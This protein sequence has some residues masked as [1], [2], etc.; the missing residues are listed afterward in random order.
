VFKFPLLGYQAS[1]GVDDR[2][3]WTVACDTEV[4]VVAIVYSTL[5]SRLI[6][7]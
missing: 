4:N 7:D 3:E 6:C 2:L 1:S 5:L